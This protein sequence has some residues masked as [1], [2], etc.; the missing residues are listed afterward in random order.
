VGGPGQRAHKR[1]GYVL[2]GEKPHQAAVG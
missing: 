1:T 2:I